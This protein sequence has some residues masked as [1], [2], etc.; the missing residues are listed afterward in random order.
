MNEEIKVKEPTKT[1]RKYER[2]ITDLEC[3]ANKAAQAG[4]SYG[5]WQAKDYSSRVKIIRKW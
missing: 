2:T 5:K 3:V 1:T 4:M